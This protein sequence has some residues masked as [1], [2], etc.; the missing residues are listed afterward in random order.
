ML[1]FN[2]YI[3]NANNLLP[4]KDILKNIYSKKIELNIINLK[5]LYLDSYIFAEAI[6][7]KLKDRQ[8]RVLRVLKLGL[9]LTKNPYFKIYLHA[10]DKKNKV[11]LLFCDK[12]LDSNIKSRILA[13]NNIG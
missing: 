4:L 12:K 5:Y 10:S 13:T 8:K 9:N 1:Y 7:R 6:T 11:N 2:S 3:F